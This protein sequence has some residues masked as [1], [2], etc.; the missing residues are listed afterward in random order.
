MYL[1]EDTRYPWIVT[2]VTEM[3]Y[4]DHHWETLPD[5]E[6]ES[7]EAIRFRLQPVDSEVEIEDESS[8]SK[9]EL[10]ERAKRSSGGSST[11]GGSGGRTYSRSKAVK[12]YALRE[13]D[14]VCQGCGEEA[15]FIGEDGEP[16]LEVH[17]LHRRSDGGPDDPDNVVALCPN[18]H[19]RVHHGKDGDEFNQKLIE[20]TTIEGKSA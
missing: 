6:G 15:P 11:S 19:R 5:Q 18:C 1:F 3:E 16:F 12:E 10:Y 9:E 8:L 17:H 20:K 13:A 4:V 14:G 7:R 2:Y